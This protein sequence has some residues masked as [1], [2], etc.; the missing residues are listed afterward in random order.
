MFSFSGN[1]FKFHQ[2]LPLAKKFFQT[3]TFNNNKK[4]VLSVHSQVSLGYQGMLNLFQPNTNASIKIIMF[5]GSQRSKGFLD[6]KTNSD[7]RRLNKL[8]KASVSIFFP[9]EN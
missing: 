5:F 6:T 2:R 9:V 8:N 4:S 1:T 3:S 7:P